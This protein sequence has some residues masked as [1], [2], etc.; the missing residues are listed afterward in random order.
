MEEKMTVAGVKELAGTKG[1]K[2]E[3]VNDFYALYKLQHGGT[4]A[5]E[6]PYFS[7]SLLGMKL[8]LEKQKTVKQMPKKKPMMR[9]R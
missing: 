3:Q 4:K 2:L 6:L 9:K 5:N 8:W 1:Y 7:R